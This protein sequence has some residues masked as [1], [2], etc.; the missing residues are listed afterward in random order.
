MG[1][2]F[3]A[4]VIFCEFPVLRFSF[5]PLRRARNISAAADAGWSWREIFC[6]LDAPGRVAS[7]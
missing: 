6:L 1:V 7:D 4:L 3:L 5:A 2:S